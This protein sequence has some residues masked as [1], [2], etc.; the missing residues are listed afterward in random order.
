MVINVCVSNLVHG[1][2][3]YSITGGRGKIPGEFQPLAA[4]MNTL[5]ISMAKCER[6]FSIMNTAISCARS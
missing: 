2:R 5:V 6:S 3:E 4:A 1:F